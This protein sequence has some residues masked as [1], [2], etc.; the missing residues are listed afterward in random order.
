VANRKLDLA[1][2]QQRLSAAIEPDDVVACGRARLGFATARA[3]H[4]L[5]S[6]TGAAVIAAVGWAI[7]PRPDLRSVLFSV[8][9]LC[10]LIPLAFP[11]RTLNNGGDYL[12]AITL[13]RVLITDYPAANVQDRVIFASP[14]NAV[15]LDVRSRRRLTEV[16]CTP[17]DGGRLLLFGRRR[18]R[19]SLILGRED[20]GQHVLAAFLSRGGMGQDASEPLA[21]LS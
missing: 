20:K 16:T 6:G 8:P 10:H 21:A 11:R 19:L 1:A 3:N 15:R 9:L 17:A 12:L 5:Y 14:I 2:A 18:R 7:S 4:L 13:D